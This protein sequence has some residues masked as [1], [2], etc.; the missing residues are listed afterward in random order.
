MSST[1]VIPGG[2]EEDPLFTSG[3]PSPELRCGLPSTACD[4]GS[5]EKGSCQ[6]CFQP[7]HK[8]NKRNN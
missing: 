8:E 1:R 5:S 3:I 2:H 7:C 4:D 6:S